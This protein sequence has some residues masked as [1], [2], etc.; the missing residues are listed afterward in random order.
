MCVCVVSVLLYF[1]C[2]KLFERRLLLGTTTNVNCVRFHLGC[3]PTNSSQRQPL[4]LRK[5]SFRIRVFSELFWVHFSYFFVLLSSVICAINSRSETRRMR[6]KTI[7]H[8]IQFPFFIG[9]REYHIFAW[10]L[11]HS[12]RKT[13]YF[14][15][16]TTTEATMFID[17]CA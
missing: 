12:S 17:M 1:V 9:I 10:W 15:W 16:Q 4:P 7:I 11:P 6:W 5:H 3:V 13:T 14:S 2:R 8:F